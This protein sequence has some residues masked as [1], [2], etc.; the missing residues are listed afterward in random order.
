[1]RRIFRISFSK[2]Y[3]SFGESV[4]RSDST[5]ESRIHLAIISPSGLEDSGAV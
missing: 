5:N 3:H 1:M 2:G 4:A